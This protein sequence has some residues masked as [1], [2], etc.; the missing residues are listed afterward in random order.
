MLAP[1]ENQPADALVFR[2]CVN[3]RSHIPSLKGSPSRLAAAETR[4]KR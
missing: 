1:T 4:T 3:C 2:C